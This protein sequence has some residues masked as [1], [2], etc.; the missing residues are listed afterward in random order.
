VISIESNEVFR[1]AYLD[2]VSRGESALAVKEKGVTAY[3]RQD[4][5]RCIERAKLEGWP[6]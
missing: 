4:L 2:L 6:K 1:Q 5:D 3:D